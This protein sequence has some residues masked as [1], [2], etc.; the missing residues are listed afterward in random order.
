MSERSWPRMMKRA[1][2]ALYCELSIAGFER[3]IA[4]GR[5]PVPVKLDGT[6]HWCK[7]TL[8][9]HLDVLAGRT[10]GYDWEREQPGLAA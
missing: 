6:D 8:D 4:S 3:E 1:T 5:L 2:A 9:E 7:V 10:S